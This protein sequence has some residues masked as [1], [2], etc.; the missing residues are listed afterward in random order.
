MSELSH[1]ALE[2]LA[3][4]ANGTVEEKRAAQEVWQRAL[5][6]KRIAVLR[7]WSAQHQGGVIIL[8]IP[9]REACDALLSGG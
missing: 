3:R 5:D 6:R 2:T 1:S 9:N 8:P 7:A 4:W